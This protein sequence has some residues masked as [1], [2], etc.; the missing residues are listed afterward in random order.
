MPPNPRYTPER[1]LDVA[2]TL[3]REAGISAVTARAVAARL[4]CSTAPVFTHFESM[5]DLLGKLMDRIIERFVEAAVAAAHGHDDPLVATGIGWL[6]FAA[7]QRRL[8]EALFLRP[9]HWHPKWGPV[10]RELADRMGA[11]PRYRDLDRATRFALVGRASIVLHGLGLE[12]WSGRLPLRDYPRLVEEL[13][14][15]VVDAALAH[16]WTADLHSFTS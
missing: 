9:D 5:E 10:R 6:R 15:P 16:G 13:A 14:R 12:I 1:I 7:E 4:G 3:T 2:L 11:H 8:Y